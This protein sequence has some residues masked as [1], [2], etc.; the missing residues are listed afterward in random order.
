MPNRP[1]TS[2]IRITLAPETLRERNRRSGSSG[3]AAIAWRVE[4]ERHQR[5]RD[6]ALAERLRR[7]PA[8]AARLHD[9]VDAEHQRAGD[10]RRAE[11]VGAVAQAEALLVREEPRGEY[12]GGDADRHVHEEDPVPRDG[13]GQHAAGEQADR[14][15]RGGDER[16]DADRLR[17]LPGLREHR[18][19]HAEDH[20][21]GH[22]AAD[23][24]QEAGA[25]QQALARGQAAEQRGER[26]ERE[27]GEEHPLAAD[28]VAEAGRRGAA[29]RRRRSGR[30]SRPTR[31]RPG[32]SRGRPGSTA[33]RRS[34]SSRRG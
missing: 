30:R 8:V 33:A 1:A 17:L 20:G 7:A 3:S 32:R 22:R 10:E 6:G 16:V 28:Q 26:E 18:H 13:L 19:D 23:A 34:R 15:A 4:E 29:G 24:L 31:G 9:R 21:R 27:A 11:H 2:S 12:R 5:E 14:G 25:D